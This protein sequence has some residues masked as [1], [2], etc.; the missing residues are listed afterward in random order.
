MKSIKSAKSAIVLSVFVIAS[1][2]S[3][4]TLAQ[5]AESCGALSN[6]TLDAAYVTTANVVTDQEDAEMPDYCRV[7]VTA[8]PSISIEVRLPMQ[9]WNGKYY[10]AGCGGFCGILGRADQQKAFVNAMGPGLKKGYATAT[11]DSGHH[12]QSVVDA[13]WADHNPNA[14]RD[15]GWRSIGETQRVAHALIDAFYGEAPTQNYFQGCSTGGRMANMAA[16]KYPDKFSG[17]ISGAPALDYTGLVALKFAWLV[18][19]NT[20][21]DGNTILKAGK[22]A[23]IGDEVMRQCDAVDGEQD[24]LIADPRNCQIDLTSLQCTSG[25]DEASCLSEAELE[26]I[27]KWRQGPQNAA[28]E[29]LYPGGIPEG[30]EPFWWLWLT[31]KVGGGGKLIPLFTQNFG[32]Y[33]AFAD[34]PGAEYSALDFDFETDPARLST[35]A[36]VYNSDSADLTAFNDAGGKMIVWH[37]W[38]DAIVTPYKTLDW[39]DK[40]TAIMGGT[41]KVDEFVRLFMIPG[42]DHCGILPGVDGLNQFS[43]DPLAALEAWVENGAAPDTIMK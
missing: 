18:Q 38:A 25:A 15:W 26:V 12:G 31:G 20:D 23:L 9:D 13:S 11:S 32:A 19:A 21:A 2:L 16:L 27:A 36:K 14:E 8:L 35:M 7:R 29:Q 4:M 22:D 42:M 17:I 28:G 39:H 33:M 10:Q 6:L 43:I 24:G 30:S 1:G 5:D 40:L 41:E 37:G 3:Q 34:D